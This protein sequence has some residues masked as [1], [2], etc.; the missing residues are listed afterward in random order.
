MLHAGDDA[1]RRAGHDDLIEVIRFH[2]VLVFAGPDDREAFWRQIGT[3]PTSLQ[4]RWGALSGLAFEQVIDTPPTAISN[5]IDASCQLDALWGQEIRVAYAVADRALVLGLPSGEVSRVDGETG[6]EI[7]AMEHAARSTVIRAA[8]ELCRTEVAAGELRD[9]VWAQRFATCAAAARRV[10]LLDR[11]AGRNF[12]GNVGDPEGLEW[13]L[14]QLGGGRPVSVHVITQTRNQNA[15]VAGLRDLYAADQ[16]AMPSELKVSFAQEKAFLDVHARHLRFEEKL[17]VS[18]DY[19]AATFAHPRLRRN[20]PCQL[21]D[22]RV[23]IERERQVIDRFKR[24][25]AEKV[26]WTR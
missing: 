16:G 14:Q 3:L 15:V 11:Y 24:R 8:R 10:T 26:L 21:S 1:L 2:G 7:V 22:A 4:Q 9:D 5:A 18:L 20:S 25:L 12:A 17:A 6:V 19:G 13:L 23:A